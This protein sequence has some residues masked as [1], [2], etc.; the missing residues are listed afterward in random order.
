VEKREEEL[1]RTAPVT[2]SSRAALFSVE[3]LNEVISKAR[4]HLLSLQDAGG[5]WVFD[6]EADC[7]I[8]AEYVLLQRF[9]GKRIPPDLVTR[10]SNYLRRR[11]LEKGG[12]PV[13]KD[14]PA[15][16]SASTKVYF[17]LKLLGDS[18]ELPHMAAARRTI[19]GL[20]G[21]SKVNVFTRITLALFGQVSWRT[22]PAIP[23]EVMLL[24]RWFF[25]HTTKISYWSRTVMIPLLILFNKQPVCRLGPRDGV[26]ELFLES[27]N[28]LVNLDHFI[29]GSC[30]KNFFIHLDRMLKRIDRFAPH[31]IRERALEKAK[32][33]TLEKMKGEG[34]IGAIFPAMVNAVMALK[35]LGFAEHHPDLVKGMAALDHLLVRHGD[36][37]FCQPCVSPVWDTCLSLSA[38][39]EE[40]IS[41]DHPS[42]TSS[43]D[44]L[45]DKQILA[46]GDWCV[47]AP[48]VEPG[49][50][51]FQF[52]NSFYP[53][54][55]DTPAV[56]M[57]IL[58][59]GCLEDERCRD[60]ITKAVEWVLGM[61]SSDGGWGA[62]DID[63]NCLYLND[64][65]FADHGALLDPSTSDLTGRCVELLSMLGFGRD[66]PAVAK[67][68]RFLRREQEPCGAWFGR[69]GVNY[70]YGTWSALMGLREAGED[71][72]QPYIRRAVQWLRSCQNPDNGWGESCYSYN[73]PSLA[74]KGKS[75][76]SQTAWALLGL[77]AAGEQGSPAVQGGIHYL[78]NSQNPLGGWDE[79][80]FTG[81]GFP[82]VFYL[83]YHGYSQY[84]PLWAL[85]VYRRL[86]SGKKTRQDEV[87]MAALR[88]R[89]VK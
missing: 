17:A 7:T 15:D 33:W 56:L 72:T 65:P 48:N 11:Q 5:Y 71:M 19:L 76:P 16:I 13:Y 36:E 34:G 35:A 31:V 45:F 85:A 27:S 61:Q 32:A 12:W 58:R 73:D 39:L 75:T 41:T 53:D 43:M 6:L 10:L 47:G 80:L 52:E 30:R 44:W 68:L 57:A 21:A 26:E 67:A 18:P 37:V 29:P 42:V 1:D 38:L 20:G 88:H 40:G 49:G 59:A 51:G 83:R 74:G 66:F 3:R 86:R 8:P 4:S 14:G 64:I 82:R 77:M 78:L 63:N 55:D 54:A 87:R 69:W 60:R 81:T 50:W 9:M 46:Q 25:F 79:D 70:L 22:V 84:F 24:P 2:E 62:F 28:D 23:I 89:R